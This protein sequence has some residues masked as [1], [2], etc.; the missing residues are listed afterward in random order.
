MPYSTIEPELIY[1]DRVVAGIATIRVRWDINSVKKTTPAGDEYT[2]WSYSETLMSWI[3]P[4]PF[5][6]IEDVQAY[7][8]SIYQTGDLS[9]GQILNWA[10]ASKISL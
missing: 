8:D 7:L 2:E 10:K 1:I 6:S 9:T 4:S 3:L 5:A